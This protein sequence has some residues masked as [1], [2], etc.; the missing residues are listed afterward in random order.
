[1]LASLSPVMLGSQGTAMFSGISIAI[2][3][4]LTR[5]SFAGPDVRS[6]CWH[7]MVL[8]LCPGEDP[9]PCGDLRTPC[10]QAHLSEL[11]DACPMPIGP[12]GVVVARK[13]P[14]GEARC[15]SAADDGCPGTIGSKE[16]ADC[17][18][19][20]AMPKTS[21]A[22]GANAPASAAVD[23]MHGLC[24]GDPGSREYKRCRWQNIV[25]TPEFQRNHP[26]SN[27]Q[28][29]GKPDPALAHLNDACPGVKPYPQGGL[30]FEACERESVNAWE[31]ATAGLPR[32]EKLELLADAEYLGVSRIPGLNRGYAGTVLRRDCPGDCQ[33]GLI[34]SRLPRMQE[35]GVSHAIQPLY[36]LYLKG[37]RDP[38][39][40]E[41]LMAVSDRFPEGD[42]PFT[43]GGLAREELGYIA[44]IDAGRPL[45]R[46]R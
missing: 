30:D 11:S 6:H 33:I 29:P 26:Q 25:L 21:K 31:A 42:P 1:M 7:E 3:L 10:I 35:N 9:S 5:S 14:K 16:Y 12:H 34:V 19:D 36:Q 8:K 46:H 23:D 32:E 18:R 41:A 37:S 39:I 22:N 15:V 40:K 20:R 13:V 45:V 44:D 4:L 17:M 38:R 28:R 2:S 24:P 27:Y 43:P